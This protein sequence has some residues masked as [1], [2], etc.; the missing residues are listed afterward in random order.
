VAAGAEA[1]IGG[2]SSD[3]MAAVPPLPP[4]PPPQ[5]VSIKAAASAQALK[6]ETCREEEIFVMVI[7]LLLVRESAL[8]INR[9][10]SLLLARRR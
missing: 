4:P 5:A 8:T 7:G 10:R 6:L 1:T 9:P 3:W 2:V